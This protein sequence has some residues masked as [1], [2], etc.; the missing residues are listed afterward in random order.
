MDLT[1]I[2]SLREQ[3]L[4]DVAV[5]VVDVESAINNAKGEL[6]VSPGRSVSSGAQGWR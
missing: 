6:S 5:H 3:V 1:G 4:D 2:K